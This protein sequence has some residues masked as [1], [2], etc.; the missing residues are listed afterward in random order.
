MD[1][2]RTPDLDN[3]SKEQSKVLNTF[4]RY[5]RAEDYSGKVRADFDRAQKVQDFELKSKKEE[6]KDDGEA[7]MEEFSAKRVPKT[8]ANALDK[9]VKVHGKYVARKKIIFAVAAVIILL[10]LVSLFVPPIYT[11]NDSESSCRREDIFAADGI[12]R[13]KA[14]I[15]EDHYV[16][17]IDAM[18]SDRSDSYRICTVA[19]DAKNYSPFEVVVDNYE[20][21]NWGDFEDNIVCSTV[22]DDSEVIPPFSTKTVKVEILVRSDGLTREE[23]DSAITSLRLYTKGTKKKIGKK[24][25]IPCIPA[26]M[27]VSDV[28]AFDP[29][30][31]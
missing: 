17:N 7:L 11:A 19:F 22:V 16:Y 12:S 4:D 10:L 2:I 27:N 21:S 26:F 29:D 30:A 24:L 6:E 9:G 1:S 8:A 31:G 23:F 18:T 28:I 14:K 3:L 25:E 15:M 5:T 13:Y 20:I